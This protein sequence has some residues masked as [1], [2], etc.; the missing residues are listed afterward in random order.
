[1]K[2][3]RDSPGAVEARAELEKVVVPRKIARE[4]IELL[5]GTV[6]IVDTRGLYVEGPPGQ[7]EAIVATSDEDEAVQ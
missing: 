7:V 1:M 6:W 4:T 3:N 5:G 2:K